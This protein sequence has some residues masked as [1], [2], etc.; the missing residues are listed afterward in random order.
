MS[1]AIQPVFVAEIP[2]HLDQGIL[3]V[4]LPY[5]IA[6]HLCAC[7]CGNEVSTPLT[8]VDWRLTFDGRASLWPSIGNWSLPCRSHYVIAHDRVRWADQWDAERIERNRM[9]ERA[10]KDRY[11]ADPAPTEPAPAAKKRRRW[12]FRRS[13]R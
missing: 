5:A 11:Y 4:S 13:T 12:P 10:A 9:R 1:E 7:G 8:P 3:Y 6:L 2:D